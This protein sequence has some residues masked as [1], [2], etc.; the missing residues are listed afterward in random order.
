MIQITSFCAKL[1]ILGRYPE[2]ENRAPQTSPFRSLYAREHYGTLFSCFRSQN[3]VSLSISLPHLTVPWPRTGITP[4][5]DWI[6]S[7]WPFIVVS[8]NP[9]Q[10]AVYGL[11][12]PTGGR[13]FWE[14]RWVPAARMKTQLDWLG[15]SRQKTMECRSGNRRCLHQR[16]Q[17]RPIPWKLTNMQKLFVSNRIWKQRTRPVSSNYRTKPRRKVAQMC[18][19]SMRID[20]SEGDWPHLAPYR[21]WGQYGGQPARGEW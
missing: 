8:I 10:H 5:A 1:I 15:Q 3:R 16:F 14:N 13:S 17:Q 9:K 6:P 2:I 21:V 20:Q 19:I 7:D 4:D 18:A 12:L 11:W